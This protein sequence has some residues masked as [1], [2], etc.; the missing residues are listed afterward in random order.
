[1]TEGAS[2]SFTVKLDAEP[3]SDVVLTVKSS[4]PETV[5]ISEDVKILTFTQYNWDQKQEVTVSGINNNTLGEGSATITLS[6][7]EGRDDAFTMLDDQT[8]AMEVTD[9]DVAGF[10]VSAATL[11]LQEGASGSFTVKLDA[12]PSSNVVLTMVSG[13]PG[14][15]M[16]SET[17]TE[18]ETESLTFT[19]TKGNWG[20]AKRFN[21]SVTD[22]DNLIK[23][24]ISSEFSIGEVIITLSVEDFSGDNNFYGLNTDL[25]IFISPVNDPPKITSVASIK[26]REDELYTYEAKVNDP[27]DN[28]NGDLVWSLSDEPSGMRVSDKGVVTWKPKEGVIRSGEVTLTVADGGEDGVV[29][30]SETFAITVTAVND[31]PVIAIG[32]DAVVTFIEGNTWIKIG[33]FLEL[34]DPDGKN[35]ELKLQSSRV[36]IK[37]F[38]SNQ[39]VLAYTKPD[40]TEFTSDSS[41]GSTNYKNP[42]GITLSFTE[43]DSTLTLE[44]KNQATVEEY[45]SL[46]RAIVYKNTSKAPNVNNRTVR[47][48]VCDSTDCSEEVLTTIAVRNRNND[49]DLNGL[50]KEIGF[51]IKGEKKDDESG[52]SV[53]NAGDVNGDG[54]DDVIIGAHKAYSGSKPNTGV[55]YVV[56]GQ[57]D[58]RDEVILSDNFDSQIGFVIAGAN[59]GDNS[60]KSV[61]NAGDVNGDGI[62]DLIIGVPHVDQVDLDKNEI[63]DAG[64]SY[65]IYG[66]VDNRSKIE[67]SSLDSN[68]TKEIGFVIKGPQSSAWTGT[69]VSNAGDVNG[70]GIDDVIIAASG[71]DDREKENVGASYVI[72]GKKGVRENV[73]LETMNTDTGFVITGANKNDYSG[74]RV[75]NAGDV[76]GD[77]Y[78]DLILIAPNANGYRAEYYVVYG[79][80]SGSNINLQNFKNENVN[81]FIIEGANKTTQQ[82]VGVSGAGDINGDGYADLIIGVPDNNSKGKSYVVYGSASGS[83]ISLAGLSEQNGFVIIG[84]P[85]VDYSGWSVSGAGDVNGDGIDDL[86]IGAHLFDVDTGKRDAGASYVIYGQVDNRSKIE[87]SSLDSNDRKEIGFVIKGVKKNDFTGRAVSGAGDVNADGY[88]DLLIG[89]HK[90]DRGSKPNT[91]ASYV[92]YGGPSN[93]DSLNEILE[94]GS[95]DDSLVGSHGDDTLNGDDGEDV[96]FGGAGGDELIIGDADFMHSDHDVNKSKID[97]GSGEDT[98]KLSS[99][100]TL[101]FSN[102]Q[103]KRNAIKNIEKIDMDGTTSMLTLRHRDVLNMSTT[104]NTLKVDGAS[105]DTLILYNDSVD[106]AV[107]K[108]TDDEENGYKTYA[109]GHATVEVMNGVKVNLGPSITITPGYFYD[110]ELKAKQTD[111]SYDKYVVAG[112]KVSDEQY[113]NHP[114][115]VITKNVLSTLDSGY[116]QVNDLDHNSGAFYAR[117]GPDDTSLYDNDFDFDGYIYLSSGEMPNLTSY[118]RQLDLEEVTLIINDDKGSGFIDTAS[119]TPLIMKTASA[120]GRSIDKGGDGDMTFGKTDDDDTYLSLDENVFDGLTEFTIQMEFKL[121]FIRDVKKTKQAYLL[122]LAKNNAQAN[123]LSIYLDREKT[124]DTGFNLRVTFQ[125]NTYPG[126]EQKVFFNEDWIEQ[127][128]R[129]TL[130]V[131]VKLGDEGVIDVHWKSKDHTNHVKVVNV[132]DDDSNHNHCKGDISNVNSLEVGID[133]A[134]FGNDQDELGGEFNKN[135]AFEGQF[136]GLTVYNKKLPPDQLTENSDSLVYSVS[137]EN[138][139]YVY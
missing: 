104:S 27:D 138:I 16:V 76:N 51:V 12:Q 121:D 59:E 2:G 70:D 69:S 131:A 135:Q 36:V 23:G 95:A 37:D 57:K 113:D 47:W 10:T 52:W 75:S 31:A 22:D 133:G 35:N 96:L 44:L 122:S 71:F 43:G 48:Q 3:L 67:L 98:L 55:S 20:E 34:S 64:A 106:S 110:K 41:E 1:M 30:S 7:K 45:Q 89:A 56:Y 94:G 115:E 91:G 93:Y 53:S 77:G 72:Y 107:W 78:A 32:E 82:L 21:V 126:A 46:L 137:A 80:A 62:D 99:S 79:S 81:G 84:E 87:L 123:M 66:Q 6:V 11:N 86:I 118:L 24:T 73:E 83:D 18:T 63:T 124:T 42:D 130:T 90:A 50:D 116:R 139:D 8:V 127:H 97:G 125:S 114:I 39:D 17:E 134:V 58:N 29:A 25:K 60:G 9:N 101:D 92:I 26:A 88:A 117:V 13:D 5:S 38:Q 105:V 85:K 132:C 100:I 4:K 28:N 14:V 119:A 15:V 65:V 136:Y 40:N 33:D 128:Q 109:H 61:S 120:S 103:F 49:V 74:T 19:F 102:K 54:V 111:T 129:G 68:D 108:G 112:Y